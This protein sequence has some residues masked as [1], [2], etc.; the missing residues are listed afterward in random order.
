MEE[1]K[2][3]NSLYAYLTSSM[4]A[5]YVISRRIGFLKK[6]KKL[7]SSRTTI[8]KLE[9][10]AK[11]NKKLPDVCIIPGI[12]KS[13]NFIK[14]ILFD[15]KLVP[16][17]E[18]KNIL[19]Q[20]ILISDVLVTRMSLNKTKRTNVHFLRESAENVYLSSSCGKYS[21]FL[22][23]HKNG[24]EMFHE[25][26]LSLFFPS[27]IVI[28]NFFH[29]T[30]K[31]DFHP[32]DLSDF[33]CLNIET[34]TE[35]EVQNKNGSFDLIQE[36]GRKSPNKWKWIP[37]TFYN[38]NLPELRNHL[39]NEMIPYEDYK[40]RV[41]EALEFTKNSNGEMSEA[42][43]SKIREKENG[44]RV[45][46]LAIPDNEKVTIV[47]KPISQVGT[48][49]DVSIHL[50]PFSNEDKKNFYFQIIKGHGFSNMILQ[51]KLALGFTLSALIISFF[52]MILSETLPEKIKNEMEIKIE[53]KRL[54]FLNF[55]KSKIK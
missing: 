45:F 7:I 44:F 55:L 41:N 37:K 40:E 35:T 20:K 18:N 1:K 21:A 46:S 2:Q 48:N 30:E 43:F 8:Q 29:G 52:F 49:G 11:A 16:F 28:A 15:S 47:A 13:D 3:I 17:F 14:P 42:E 27:K 5:M 12:L 36:I 10:L 26:D 51:Y 6:N 32:Q 31:D 34:K 33:V 9:K 53:Q 19:N 25:D 38:E 54:D 39:N 50:V 4:L 22:E 24:R 23:F